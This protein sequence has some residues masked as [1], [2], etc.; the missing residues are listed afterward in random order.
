MFPDG[1]SADWRKLIVSPIVK[2]W[3]GSEDWVDWYE[4]LAEV[5]KVC[6]I[7]M[8]IFGWFFIVKFNNS[9][10]NIVIKS[11]TNNIK[12]TSG[13]FDISLLFKLTILLMGFSL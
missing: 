5:L 1:L 3:L 9:I 8:T 2:N 11:R 13:K 10:L 6:I 4:G 12:I 7:L